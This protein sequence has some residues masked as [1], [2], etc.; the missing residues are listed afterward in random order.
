MVSTRM[1]LSDIE[2]LQI[3]PSSYCNARCPHCPRFDCIE[4]DVFESTGTLHPDLKQGHM[5]INA[6]IE[7]LQVDQLSS[8]KYVVLEGDKGDPLMHPNIE[9]FIEI[10][11]NLP[12]EPLI[13]LNTN[14]SIR[15][16]V[17]WQDLAKKQYRLKVVF[18]IDGLADTNHLYR[19]GLDYNKIINNVNAFI[20]GGGYAVWK[21]IVF[22]HNEHQIDEI[23]KF[24]QSIG[25]SEFSLR[26]ADRTRFKN[27]NK[28]PVKIDGKLS[29]YLEVPREDRG[30]TTDYVFKKTDNMIPSRRLNIA[31]RVCPNLAKGQLYITHQNYVLPCCMMHFVTEHNYFGKDDF[32]KLAGNVENHSLVSNTLESILQNQFFFKTL[33]DSLKTNNRHHICNGCN[34]QIN[35]NLSNLVQG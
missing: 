6:I 17:W 1:K 16:T 30:H 35:K 13:I 19:V 12:S 27:L 2:M 7:N 23:K 24:S 20:A 21:M 3:E 8:L 22:A 4:H 25:C 32:L 10:F 26:Q 15:N 9:K 31:N 11:S 18:S 5:D 14:G 33:V 29:H 34:Q 28:W